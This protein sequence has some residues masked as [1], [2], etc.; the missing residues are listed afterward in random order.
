MLLPHVPY[1]HLLNQ[2]GE[3]TI[4]GTLVDFTNRSQDMFNISVSSAA[5]PALPG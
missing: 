3:S 2:E 1:Q 4:Y 5:S